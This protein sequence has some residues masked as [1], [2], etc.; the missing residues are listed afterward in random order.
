M[1]G[2]VHTFFMAGLCCF[3]IC[4]G[5]NG[6]AMGVEVGDEGNQFSDGGLVGTSGP[7]GQ[8]GDF[9]ASRFDAAQVRVDLGGLAPNCSPAVETCNQMDDDCDGAIDE[10]FNVGEAC[11][12]VLNNCP[13]M[14][15]T[16]CNPNNDTLTICVAGNAA[17]P[18]D[19]TC[20][21]LD[22]DCDGNVDEGFPENC[23]DCAVMPEVC[24]GQDDDCDGV[25]DEDAGNGQAQ[26]VC[27]GTDDDC[28]GQI[29]EGNVCP[30]PAYI[31]E[32]HLYLF[33]GGAAAMGGNQ[34]ASTQ[35][36]ST[37]K[38]QCEQTGFTLAKIESADENAFIYD[39]S[40]TL[41]HG[42]TWLGLND[43]QSEGRWVWADETALGYQNW[44]GGEPNNGGGGEDCGILLMS[45]GRESFWDD[46]PC[47]RSYHFICE[48]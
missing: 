48:Q 6:C 26:E 18:T 42:D 21:G 33:C 3:V 24:N 23:Q 46:R 13:T 7:S 38:V 10:M 35:V 30:C 4:S 34:Y 8:S 11:S 14:G 28:D 47:D 32:N 12:V 31:H 9:G 29:D 36:W 39:T 45:P 43:L 44:D 40:R 22:D 5:L 27:N 1:R 16:Q 25:V 37:A 15:L 20:N 2:S 41:G 17:A 19:E